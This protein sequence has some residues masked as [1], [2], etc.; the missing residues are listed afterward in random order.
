[1]KRAIIQAGLFWCLA[2]MFIQ[3]A[4]CQGVR[5]IALSGQ[6]AQGTIGNVWFAGFS[7]PCI[8]ASGQVAFKAGLN[9]SDVANGTGAGIWTGAP[10]SLVLLIRAGD[11]AAGLPAGVRYASG[12]G[13]NNFVFSASG[14]IAVAADLVGTG[15]DSSNRWAIFTGTTGSINLVMRGGDQAPGLA[16]GVKLY[17][18]EEL[19]AN[20]AGQV[21]LRTRL[22]G[23]DVNSSNEDAI[24]LGTGSG[25]TLVARAGEQATG[26][27][28]GVNYA[29]LGNPTV[30]SS[31]HVAFKAELVGGRPD[32]WND[33]SVWSNRSGSNALLARIGDPAPGTS[34]GVVFDWLEGDYYPALNNADKTI[35]EAMLA[36]PG[37]TSTNNFGLWSDATGSLSLIARAG[38][39]A[40][41]FPGVA[42]TAFSAPLLNNAGQ[43]AFIGTLAG[44]GVTG[45]NDNG[46]WSDRSGQLSMIARKGSQP[47]GTTAGT[48]FENFGQD[49]MI[50]EAGQ[51]AFGAFLTGLDIKDSSN[52]YG[53]WAQDRAGVLRLIVREGDPIQVAPGDSRTVKSIEYFCCTSGDGT[54][55]AFNALGQ[56][57]FR[58]NFTDGTQGIFISDVA[59]VPE[60]GSI[61]IIVA[62]AYTLLLRA[63]SFRSHKSR[64]R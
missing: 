26:L 22:S 45:S 64:A 50:N 32:Y 24:W 51:V 1:M 4:A 62:I 29:S 42:F 13:L 33:R 44:T 58:A 41:G 56:L 28:T 27:A 16:A 49:M 18:M 63:N 5:A 43:A 53:L 11:Q 15:I 30:N 48:S 39:Q 38:D 10:E 55:N 19:R 20:S 2:A 9:G 12:S 40:P 47:P 7:A 17:D 14:K 52:D 35:F 36:G 31:G 54:S 59:A 3:V 8:N 60:P 37:V 23:T 21:A 46:I 61:G 6:P 34:A 25:L 57:A